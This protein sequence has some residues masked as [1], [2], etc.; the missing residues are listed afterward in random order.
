MAFQRD[1]L[2]KLATV[3]DDLEARGLVKKAAEVDRVLV[4]ALLQQAGIKA[5]LGEIKELVKNK[6]W[7][8]LKNKIGKGARAFALMTMIVKMLI[9][10]GEVSADTGRSFAE[11]KAQESKDFTEFVDESGRGPD[12]FDELDE[13]VEKLE[14][15][16]SETGIDIQRA[17]NDPF[18]SQMR[19]KQVTYEDNGFLT[20]NV[21][22]SPAYIMPAI[23]ETAEE[24]KE[25]L[26][27]R[28]N[29]LAP[30]IKGKIGLEPTGVYIT[31]Y[32]GANEH[33]NKIVGYITMVF[34][35]DDFQEKFGPSEDAEDKGAEETGRRVT[36]KTV[37][38]PDGTIVKTDAE[39]NETTVKMPPILDQPD[40]AAELLGEIVRAEV[41]VDIEEGKVLTITIDGTEEPNS[42]KFKEGT[43][44][45]T[46]ERNKRVMRSMLA[47]INTAL[48]G[49]GTAPQNVSFDT[50]SG[51]PTGTIRYDISDM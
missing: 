49:G 23:G 46:V 35:T 15:E 16:D 24:V 30:I 4:A 3:A 34:D 10:A 20:P 17:Q 42:S 2:L 11:F 31:F 13:E 19:E 50:S 5:Q 45:R 29:K 44:N 6:D 48:T 26:D 51:L 36:E 37:L 43:D 9:G 47:K 21:A 7:I 27:G 28:F 32:E 38:H 14:P 22:G 18:R 25:V 8:G 41:D 33:S 12:L 40:A 39:G 1:T